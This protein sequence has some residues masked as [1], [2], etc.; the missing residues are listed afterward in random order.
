MNGGAL[1]APVTTAPPATRA[2][3]P[4]ANTISYPLTIYFDA[5]CPLCAAEMA[6][7]ARADVAGKLRLVDCSATGFVDADCAAAGI[8]V[9]ALMWRLHAR[10]AAGQ[11]RV[12]VPAFAAA[13]DAIGVGGLAA[14]W[15]DPR[16]APA[17]RRL[18]GWVA[19]HRQGLSRLGLD[20][21]FGLWVGWVS[22]R[23]QHRAATCHDGVCER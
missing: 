3:P 8:E 6:A 15:T 9:S 16:W 10:D 18:Y 21:L 7:I 12:G 22:R 11:W 19:D 13:Y 5:S 17:L 4:G 20:R 2:A 14:F 1:E 23:A